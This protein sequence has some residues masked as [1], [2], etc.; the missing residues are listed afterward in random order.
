MKREVAELSGNFRGE[1]SLHDGGEGVTCNLFC[2]KK[3]ETHGT[4]YKA[5]ETL[6]TLQNQDK[7]PCTRIAKTVQN[8]LGGKQ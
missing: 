8:H 2:E 6:Y 3:Y 4:V 7:S 1:L 5:S